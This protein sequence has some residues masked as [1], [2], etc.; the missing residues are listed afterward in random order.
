M[1][2]Y[3]NIITLVIMA[4]APVAHQEIPRPSGSP[5]EFAPRAPATAGDHDDH[6]GPCDCKGQAW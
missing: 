1:K 3:L 5:T 6:G 2:A 4:L